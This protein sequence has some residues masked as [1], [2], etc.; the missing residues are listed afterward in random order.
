[1]LTLNNFKA[2]WKKEFN[3]N[4]DKFPSLK[5]AVQNIPNNN[6]QDTNWRKSTFLKNQLSKDIKANSNK[7]GFNNT[8]KQQIKKSGK[9]LTS[10][11]RKDLAK[12]VITSKLGKGIGLALTGIGSIAA[13]NKLRKTRS[14]RGMKRGNYSK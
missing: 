14:D 4:P 1:M 8:V 5:K 12:R 9:Y 13:I 7:P 2:R 3:K 6:D 10:N 11:S